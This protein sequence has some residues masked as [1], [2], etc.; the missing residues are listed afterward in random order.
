[1]AR[2]RLKA[3]VIRDALVMHAVVQKNCPTAETIRI[4]AARSVS[5]AEVKM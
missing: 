5:S 2:S 1:M 4:V 3:K